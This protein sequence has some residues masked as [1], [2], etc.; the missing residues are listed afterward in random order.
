MRKL[1]EI[2]EEVTREKDILAG[3]QNRRISESQLSDLKKEC[4]YHKLS[5]DKNTE[6]LKVSVKEDVITKQRAIEEVKNE[7]VHHLIDYAL[8]ETPIYPDEPDNQNS[9]YLAIRNC[10]I[11]VVEISKRLKEQK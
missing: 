6:M 3:Y 4:H 10:I 5:I 7:I 2:R 1:I 9:V 8:Q 11:A